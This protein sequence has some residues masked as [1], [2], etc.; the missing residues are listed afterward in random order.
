[1]PV[2]TVV[3]LQF[4]TLLGGAVVT[5]S[6]FGWPGLGR[7]AVTAINQRDIPIVQGT[8]LTLAVTFSLVN[9]VVDLAYAWINPR[10][11]YG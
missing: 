5:E 10:I 2:V 3:G 4:G 9:L 7:L 8:V 1:L 6:I 11:R